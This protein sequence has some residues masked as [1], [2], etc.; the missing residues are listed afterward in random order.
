M[1]PWI[2]RLYG[3]SELNRIIFWKLS[4]R[5]SSS[6][7]GSNPGL[8]YWSIR[9]VVEEHLP[10]ILGLFHPIIFFGVEST[11]TVGSCSASPSHCTYIRIAYITITAH[12]PFPTFPP[13]PCQLYNVEGFNNCSNCIKVSEAGHHK[14]FKLRGPPPLYRLFFSA[15][16]PA[17][18]RSISVASPSPLHK[19]EPWRRPG[20]SSGVC[21]RSRTPPSP[22]FGTQAGVYHLRRGGR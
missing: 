4:D 6:T 16:T 15:S 11:H 5:L 13:F 17:P 9:L 1:D 2:S 10:K 7:S 3:L 8:T 12:T 20:P 22:Q 14:Y 18:R 21:R 19:S